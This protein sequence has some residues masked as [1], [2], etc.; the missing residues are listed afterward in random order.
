MKRTTLMIAAALFPLTVLACDKPKDDAKPQNDPA[1]AGQ[2]AQAAAASP[3]A[4]TNANAATNA[5]PNANANATANANNA[6]ARSGTDTIPES[7]LVT[8]A[9]FEE[10][11]E[12]AI[13]PK[14]YKSEL[15]ALETEVTAE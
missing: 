5:D 7:D 6:P 12:K 14:N 3:N 1:A 4:N 8:S 9:D 11:A 15:T 2:G 13:T 10:E